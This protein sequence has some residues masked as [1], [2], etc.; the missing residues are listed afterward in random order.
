L[1]FFLF[2]STFFKSLLLFFF[3]FTP[4]YFGWLGILHCYFFMFDFYVVTWPH[5]L[6]HKF[7]RLDRVSFNHFLKISFIII[8]FIGNWHSFFFLFVLDSFVNLI[9]FFN[10]ALQFKFFVCPLNLFFKWGP[11]FLNCYFCTLQKKF[12]SSFDILFIRIW[13]P[14]FFPLFIG[15]TQK[16]I[17]DN[18]RVISR[19]SWLKLT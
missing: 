6:Y 18:Y 9:F 17:W 10:F 2:K 8:E 12:I 14:R 1:V 16:S 15:P 19:V 13:S 7:W 11:Y 4:D 3:K 5:D